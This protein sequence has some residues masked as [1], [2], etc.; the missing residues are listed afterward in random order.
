MPKI[1]KNYY[2]GWTRKALTFSIDD[3]N[4]TYDEKFINIVKPYGIRGAFNLCSPK[5]DGVTPEQ[6][7]DFYRGFEIANHC[8]YHPVTLDPQAGYTVYDTPLDRENADLGG[9]YP[10]DKFEGCHYV[11]RG[12][13]WVTAAGTEVY[14]RLADEC[15]TELEE[16]FGKGSIKGFVWPHGCCYDDKILQHM[17]DEGYLYIRYT[18]RRENDFSMP[19]SFYKI[20]LN[21]RYCT[22]PE[23]GEAFEN[24]RDDGT[25]KLLT[26]GVHSV[27]YDK[28]G[29][30]AD[31][32]AFCQKFGNQPEKYCSMTC[33]DVFEYKAALDSVEVTDTKIINPTDKELY[34]TVDGDR[35]KLGS[36]TEYTI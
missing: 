16:V 7:R 35:V 28:G 34:I 11:F 10:H 36:K 32:L 14:N 23:V 6:Y 20:G 5:R 1:D 12:K 30:W 3:G 26:F 22:L 21:G 2:P 27:D 24:E 31:L 15:R 8:K 18:T 9:I 33:A 4:L 29:T 13:S 19:D 17:K 25:L